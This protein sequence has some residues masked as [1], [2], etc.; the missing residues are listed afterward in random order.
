MSHVYSSL[1]A[2][3]VLR[4]IHIS[5]FR[6][7]NFLAARSWDLA[8]FLLEERKS[9]AKRKNSTPEG[10]IVLLLRHLLSQAVAIS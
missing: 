2:T 5:W 4:E 6:A 10:E 3:R 1:C 7:E 8:A 9:A